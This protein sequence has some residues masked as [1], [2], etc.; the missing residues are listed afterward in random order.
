M[1]KSPQPQGS[2]SAASCV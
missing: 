1:R 2:K